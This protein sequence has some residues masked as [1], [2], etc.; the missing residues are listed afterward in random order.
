MAC[1][2]PT[3]AGTAAR[4]AGSL[5]P[6]VAASELEVAAATSSA[7]VPETARSLHRPVIPRM[8]ELTPYLLQ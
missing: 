2:P 5:G 3:Q 7:A 6:R 8:R 1:A 4:C